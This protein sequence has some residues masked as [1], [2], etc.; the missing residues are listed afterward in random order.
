MEKSPKGSPGTIS[1]GV[2]V[3]FN[4]GM[5]TEILEGIV[6]KGNPGKVLKQ[7]L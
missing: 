4:V 3:E 6:P 1:D 2:L 5:L 7:F